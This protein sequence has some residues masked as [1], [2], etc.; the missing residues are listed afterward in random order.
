MPS[1]SKLCQALT[2]KGEACQAPALAGDAFCFWH[3][4][5][6]AKARAEARSKGGRA[7]HERKVSGVDAPPPR[8]KGIADLL[9][10]VNRALTDLYCL[11]NSIARARCVAQLAGV[12]VKVLELSEVAERLAAVEARLDGWQNR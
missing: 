9:P 10:L 7:R 5:A 11:E 2:K 8:V 6:Q 4:P 3:S 1:T 12:L